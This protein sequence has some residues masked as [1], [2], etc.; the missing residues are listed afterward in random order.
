[1]KPPAPLIF[2]SLA[3]VAQQRDV[4]A[5]AAPFPVWP[6]PK[7]FTAASAESGADSEERLVISPS[8][9]LLFGEMKDASYQIIALVGQQR[10]VVTH[11]S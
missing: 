6:L 9:K 7:A 1:M 8:L 10:G 11:F 4:A 2:C 3:L 5:S